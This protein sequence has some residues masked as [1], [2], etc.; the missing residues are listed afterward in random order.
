MPENV[1]KRFRKSDPCLYIN[2]SDAGEPVLVVIT[3][4]DVGG[5]IGT[6]DVVKEVA[7]ALGEVYK[8]NTTA[9]MGKFVDCHVIDTVN[10]E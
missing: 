7:E 2:K 3:Y 10:I 5:N 6:P 1:E 9:D 4:V 8:V